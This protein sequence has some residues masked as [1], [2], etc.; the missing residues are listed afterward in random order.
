MIR[1]CETSMHQIVPCQ[2]GWGRQDWDCNKNKYVEHSCFSNP[3][4]QF[5]HN[6]VD[7]KISNGYANLNIIR[8]SPWENIK[9]S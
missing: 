1:Y 7:P 5:C 2:M 4:L 9:L 6:L 3:A 8:L